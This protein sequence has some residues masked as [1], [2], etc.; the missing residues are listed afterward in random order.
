MSKRGEGGSVGI[1]LHPLSHRVPGR[2]ALGS[3]LGWGLAERD[4]GSGARSRLGAAAAAGV[5]DPIPGG[6][7][8]AGGA[9]GG[10]A[11]PGWLPAAWAPFVLRRRGR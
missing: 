7:G 4:A 6:A 3:P 10:R 1:R 11:G 2:A 9:A 8:R 5:A